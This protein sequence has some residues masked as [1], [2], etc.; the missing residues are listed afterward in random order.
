MKFKLLHKIVIS[1][2]CLGYLATV[3]MPAHAQE[4]D[5]DDRWK[6]NTAIYL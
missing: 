2:L 6:F 3:P 5:T 4:T 1:A